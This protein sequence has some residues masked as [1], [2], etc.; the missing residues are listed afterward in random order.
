MMLL[1]CRAMRRPMARFFEMDFDRHAASGSVAELVGQAALASD[2]QTRTIGLRRSAL[3]SW[4]AMDDS[5]R[6]W[7]PRIRE[8]GQPI[9]CAREALP[10]GIW[11]AVADSRR[12]PGPPVVSVVIN[13]KGAGSPARSFDSGKEQTTINYGAYQQAAAAAKVDPTALYFG[14]THRF[15]PPDTTVTIP[16]FQPSA[17][18]DTQADARSLAASAP[19]QISAQ[20]LKLAQ[21]W[22]D[23][24]AGNA[25]LAPTLRSHGERAGSNEFAVSGSVTASGKPII[26]NDPHLTLALPPIF[27]E[28]HIIAHD[29]AYA[30]PLNATGVKR[31]GRAGASSRAAIRISAGAPRSIRWIAKRIL[32]GDHLPRQQRRSAE[33]PSCTTEWMS[34]C[35]GSSRVSMSTR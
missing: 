5:T 4:Q 17:S 15:A 20:T 1:S 31:A 30:Q 8:W 28:M 12:N 34:P 13:A 18:A 2:V 25:F 11:R 6:G 22:R 10:L 14:D 7:P 3:A 16:N 9:G 33:L 19:A 24:I 27:M 32:S 21:A 26:A 29:P 35:S 23:Q